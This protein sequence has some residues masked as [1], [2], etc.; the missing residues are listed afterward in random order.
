MDEKR[1]ARRFGRIAEPEQDIGRLDRGAGALDA[2]RF[3]R[4]GRLAKAGGVDQ[5]EGNAADRHRRLDQIAGG[6]GDRGGDGRVAAR[7]TH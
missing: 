3:D 7:L 4:V 2:D 6:A 1:L 5:Q